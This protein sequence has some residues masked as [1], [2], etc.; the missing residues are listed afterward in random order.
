[1]DESGFEETTFRRSGWSGKGQK[2]YGDQPVSRRIRTNLIA[3]KSGKKLLAPV[4]FEGA[5]NASWFNTWLQEH[6]FKELPEGATVIMD[7]AAFHKTP[8]TRKIFDQSLFHLLYLPPYSP[9]LNPIE[10]VFANLKKRRQYA[11]T[12]TPLDHFVKSYGDYLE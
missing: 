8:Q 7:N 4:L 12:N 5:T 9:D 6:L 2:I 1:M 11:P 3:G 10:K